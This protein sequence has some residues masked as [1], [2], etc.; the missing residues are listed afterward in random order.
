MVRGNIDE[1]SSEW[2]IH[3]SAIR[4]TALPQQRRGAPKVSHLRNRIIHFNKMALSP[5]FRVCG[6][7]KKKKQARYR[8][9]VILL[10]SVIQSRKC[11]TLKLTRPQAFNDENNSVTDASNER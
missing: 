6:L 11:A 4:T 5:S 7:I 1:I 3:D 8:S 10:K 9:Q 2:H